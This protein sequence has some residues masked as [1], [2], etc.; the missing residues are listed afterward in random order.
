[1]E[2]DGLGAVAKHR[3][4]RMI[5]SRNSIVN[6]ATDFVAAFNEESSLIQVL[7]VTH[8]EITNIN[9]EL[10]LDYVF[11]NAVN[12]PNITSYH[13]LQVRNGKVIGFVTSKEGYDS[14][15]LS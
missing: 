10:E 6:C 3:V 4:R 9:A 1:M 14:I 15:N 12:V 2:L 11:D 5:L 7:E 8:S 13:Q